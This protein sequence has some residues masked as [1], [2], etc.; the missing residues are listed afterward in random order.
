V[1]LVV[2]QLPNGVID[3]QGLVAGHLSTHCCLCC[4]SSSGSSWVEG[5][6]AGPTGGLGLKEGR[7]RGTG[8]VGI[9]NNT[10]QATMGS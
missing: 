6:L 2:Q 8:G 1:A 9:D 5:G 4:L 7:D 10:T 3:R